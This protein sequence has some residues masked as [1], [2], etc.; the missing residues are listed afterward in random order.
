[1]KTLET[2]DLEQRLLHRYFKF[3][4]HIAFEVDLR[5][6]MHHTYVKDQMSS[7]PKNIKLDDPGIADAVQVDN[8]G[9]ITCFELKVTKSDFHSD[10]KLSFI[11]NKNYYVMPEKLYEQVKDEIPPNIGV[12]VPLG[13]KDLQSVKKCKSQEMVFDKEAVLIAMVTASHNHT[14]L[15]N[16]MEFVPYMFKKTER[17]QEPNTPRFDKKKHRFARLEDG[18]IEP[19][20]YPDGEKRNFYKDEDRK[21]RMD[22]DRYGS[23]IRMYMSELITE[24]LEEEEGL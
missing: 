2:E 16:L 9:V 3:G 23:G 13:N 8:Y 17:P 14:T 6:A 21:W 7:H 11:G 5:G 20:Y 12:L 4:S 10:A 24:F 19:L 15:S 1:M 22:F 18:T